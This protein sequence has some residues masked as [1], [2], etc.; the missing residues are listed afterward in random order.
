MKRGVFYACI[1][2]IEIE[3]WHPNDSINWDITS[4]YNF[5]SYTC[6]TTLWAYFVLLW[7]WGLNFPLKYFILFVDLDL[8]LVVLDQANRKSKTR[9]VLL[10]KF[11]TRWNSRSMVC[12]Y[13][14]LELDKTWNTRN[15][16]AKTWK[17]CLK[18][19][20]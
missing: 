18:T 13:E 5:I 19:Q 12:I 4:T 11:Q 9:Q 6:L 8:N 1:H 7:W 10:L 14:K 17:T 16:W 20:P 2:Y 15:I 3:G